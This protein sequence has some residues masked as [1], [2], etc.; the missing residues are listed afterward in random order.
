ML[1]AGES[2]RMLAGEVWALNNSTQHGAWNADAARSRTHMICDFTASPA[3]L[4]LLEQGERGLG[5]HPLEV[6]QHLAKFQAR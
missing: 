1:C 3:L 4:A 2:Y 5:S 6:G